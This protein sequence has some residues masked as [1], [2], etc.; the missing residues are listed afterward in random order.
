MKFD[1]TEILTAMVTPFDEKGEL[2]LTRLEKLI[3]HLL[4]TGTEGL[5]VNGTTGEGPTLEHDEKLA[6]IKAAAKIIAGRVPLMVGTGSNNTKQTIAFTK[7]VAA[8]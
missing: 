2:S 5:L 1:N 6:L 4:A 3:N 7:E 8:I